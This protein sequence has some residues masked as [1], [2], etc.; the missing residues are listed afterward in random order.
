MGKKEEKVVEE[1][2]EVKE[3]KKEEKKKSVSPVWIGTAAVVGFM[4]GF[5]VL[6]WMLGIIRGYEESQIIYKNIE[7]NESEESEV[8]PVNDEGEKQNSSWKSLGT[9]ISKVKEIHDD[10]APYTYRF[11]RSRGGK[12]FYSYEL[13]SLAA[14]NI[15]E[16]DLT[17]KQLD[18]NNYTYKAKISR[19][20]VD[21]TLNKY[22]GDNYQYDTKLSRNNSLGGGILFS[23]IS[24]DDE[25][26]Q[27]GVYYHGT[28]GTSGPRPKIVN[29]KVQ[30]V[31]EKDDMIKVIE[32]IIYVNG[33]SMNDSMYYEIYADPGHSMFIT[34]K[35]FKI[36]GI[37]NQEIN[38]DEFDAASVLTSIYK[39]G[40][41]GYYFVSS[42]ISDKAL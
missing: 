11:N 40:N 4:L 29:R 2:E 9:D 37:E 28:D 38:V 34:S 24:Y 1:K 21:A 32:K 33:R 23:I 18:Q 41:D 12:S 35:T 17:D 26:K 42:D 31:F 36:E 22:F 13:L 8:L 6:G 19:D 39:K 27:F 20:K 25:T 16:E 7:S 15:K 10:L 5:F 30:E 14:K 3:V